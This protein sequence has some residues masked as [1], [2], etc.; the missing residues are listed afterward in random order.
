MVYETIRMYPIVGGQDFL[1]SSGSN[2]LPGLYPKAF[3]E[4]H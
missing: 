4:R 3:G 1:N 2:P